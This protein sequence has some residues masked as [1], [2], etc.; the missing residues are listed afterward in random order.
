MHK[1]KDI[2]ALVLLAICLGGALPAWSQKTAPDIEAL[3]KTAPKVYIDCTRCDIN[4]IK[5]E[6]TFVNY[7]RDR[8]EAQVH[9]LIT[10]MRTGG[11]GREYTVS[12]LG[13]NEFA[14]VNDIQK[15]YSG[16]TDTDDEIRQGLV[17]VLKIG[18]MPYVARTPIA[19]RIALNWTPEDKPAEGKDRWNF[20]VF[21]LS[22]SGYFNGESSYK[23]RSLSL[24]CSA[25]RVTPELKI[26][27]SAS[28]RY[29]KSLF[30]YDSG[31]IE[32][33]SDSSSFNGLIVKSLDDH[34]SVGGYFEAESSTYENI[35]VGVQVAPAVEF[36][37]FPYSESTR[38]Q[39]RFLYKMGF[40]TVRYREETIFLKTSEKLWNESLSTSLELKEKWGTISASLSGS[41]YFHDFSKYSLNLFGIVSLQLVKGLNLFALGSGS[42]IHDQL[43][44]IRA[45]ATL[46]EI[47]LQRRQL[48]TTYNYFFSVGLS[49]T[50]GSVYTN[51]V[52]PRFGSTGGGG[53]SISIGD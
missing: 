28:T 36:N 46:D 41:H 11:G 27:L 25:N 50:V 47:L 53:M 19:S 24:N 42:R 35:R 15:Y 7:V 44:L 13:Q 1:R 18:L 14:D 4:Y 32:S 6:I 2:L 33:P 52:N 10:T 3:K 51:V 26:G 37:L 9:I 12:F 17:K 34:W 30:S 16:K 43:S 48:A 20:W 29:S 21:S 40:R 22:G 31:S 49:F 39:L 8:N 45:G 23:Y 5:T 38:R